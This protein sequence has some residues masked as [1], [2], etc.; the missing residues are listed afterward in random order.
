MVRGMKSFLDVHIV[1]DCAF[2]LTRIIVACTI[3]NNASCIIYRHVRSIMTLLTNIF[4]WFL[5]IKYQLVAKYG[6][7]KGGKS[8][9]VHVH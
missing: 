9:I 3:V 1:Y 2:S 4:K 7:G 8:F 5:V 6:K